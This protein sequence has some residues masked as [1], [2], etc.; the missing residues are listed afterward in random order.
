M[1]YSITPEFEAL[2]GQTRLE[3]LSDHACTV[4]GID[5]EYRIVYLNPAWYQFSKDNG[6]NHSI[7]EKWLFG[8]NVFDCIPEV[9]EPFYKNLFESSLNKNDSRVTPLHF[10]YECS[11]PTV[12][13]EFTMHLYPVGSSGIIVVHSINI[14]EPHTLQ[15]D[16]EMLTLEKE[17]YIDDSGFVYQCANCRRVKNLQEEKRWDWI[18]KLVEAPVAKTSHGICDPCAAHYYLST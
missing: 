16:L 18:P 2:I 5:S 4:Y 12:F 8:R 9:L 11:S 15:P 10:K 6:T 17:Q 13:R 1:K 3:S 7:D 14:E